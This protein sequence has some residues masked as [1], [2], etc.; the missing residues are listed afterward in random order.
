MAAVVS[1]CIRICDTDDCPRPTR[2]NEDAKVQGEA[3]FSEPAYVLADD[4]RERLDAMGFHG[5][6]DADDCAGG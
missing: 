6:L 3:R 2:L 1:D 4:G 5:V